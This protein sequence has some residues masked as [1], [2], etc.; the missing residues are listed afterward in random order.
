MRSL[1]ASGRITG[2]LSTHDKRKRLV[3]QLFEAV[4]DARSLRW[5]RAANRR[6]DRVL[7]AITEHDRKHG[8]EH[9]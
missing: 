5:P 1:L 9:G 4:E 2:P 6:I 7:D 8:R 3:D